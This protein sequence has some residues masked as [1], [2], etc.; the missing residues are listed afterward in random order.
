MLPATSCT[1]LHIPWGPELNDIVPHDVAGMRHTTLPR[2][3]TRLVQL[4]PPDG[5]SDDECGDAGHVLA[6]PHPIGGMQGVIQGL[7]RVYV[8]AM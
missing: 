4:A 3:D 5:G 8:G 6:G 1:A 7:Y 2:G